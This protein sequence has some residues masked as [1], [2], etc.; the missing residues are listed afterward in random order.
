MHTR[1]DNVSLSVA[2]MGTFSVQ[3]PQATGA[4]FNTIVTVSGIKAA[5]AL[6]VFPNKHNS[7][8]YGFENSTGYILTA[9]EPEDGQIVLYFTNLGQATGY[10]DRWYSYAVAR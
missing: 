7:A 1:N 2:T 9:A 4:D 6:V 10:V 8:A 3:L 5:D